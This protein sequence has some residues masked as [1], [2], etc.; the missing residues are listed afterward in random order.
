MSIFTGSGGA[1]PSKTMSRFSAA[2]GIGMLVCVALFFVSPA[3]AGI[4]FVALWLL[5]MVGLIIYHLSN[6]TSGR[7][8]PHTRF[9]MQ[10]QAGQS[11]QAAR[12]RDLEKLRQDGLISE[13]EYRAKRTDIMG[14][15]W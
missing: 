14:E 15:D 9:E 12:L 6:A 2:V 11:D 4:A 5:V 10:G 3:V 1:Y 13:A 8:V 7:G